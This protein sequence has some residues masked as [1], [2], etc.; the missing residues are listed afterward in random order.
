MKEKSGDE[1]EDEENEDDS[2]HIVE[3]ESTLRAR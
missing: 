3:G 1:D 2:A